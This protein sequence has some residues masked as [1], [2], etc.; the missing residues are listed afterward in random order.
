MLV[1]KIKKHNLISWDIL[2]WAT[3]K[4]PIRSLPALFYPIAHLLRV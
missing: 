2:G 1:S 4:V 3:L